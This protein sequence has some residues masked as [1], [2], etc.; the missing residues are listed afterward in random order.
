MKSPPKT[1]T[2][3]IPLFSMRPQNSSQENITFPRRLIKRWFH[4]EPNVLLRLYSEKLYGVLT[5]YNIRPVQCERSQHT[6]EKAESLRL[7]ERELIRIPTNRSL[8]LPSQTAHGPNAPDHGQNLANGQW[9]KRPRPWQRQRFADKGNAL[10][11]I[12]LQ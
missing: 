10:P 5:P 9:A 12:Y 4:T 1:A 3:K 11:H 6:R 8:S 7:R 2:R